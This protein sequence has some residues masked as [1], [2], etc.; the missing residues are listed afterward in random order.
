MKIRKIVFW[1]HLIAGVLASV[2]ILI[3]SFTGVLLAYETQII[4]RAESSLRRV[5]PPTVGKPLS[6]DLLLNKARAAASDSQPTGL[7]IHSEPDASLLVNFGREDVLYINPY[8]G[9]VLGHGSKMRRL[10]QQIE[11][12]HR[13]LGAG[14]NHRPAA[15][16]VASAGNFVFL[17]LAISGL[18][19][20]WPRN[21]SWN[22][23]RPS[24]WFVGG[25]RGKARDWNWHN[26]I[27]LWC[28][29]V[30]IILTLTGVVMSYQ[31]ANNLL[32]KLTGNP[33][34]PPQVE[35]SGGSQRREKPSRNDADSEIDESASLDVLVIKAQ[36]Q[37][38]GWNTLNFRLP[39]RPGAPVIVSIQETSKP[40]F[41]RSQLTLNSS[42]A[43]VIKWEP[44][45]A[46][47]SGRKLRTW[48][49]FLHTGEAGGMVGQTIAGLA[50]AGGVVLVCTGLA[51]ACR[52]FFGRRSPA[53]ST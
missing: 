3:M 44:F 13:W 28:S 27:G 12:W 32:Y 48:A 21:W 4:N 11:T 19:L 45:S 34:P 37:M 49:R 40:S 20:W 23:L 30:L 38:P 29:P 1:L 39:Q 22:A 47:N 52:R 15:L 33:P 50:S 17:F 5:V 10:M 51:M 41:Y 6:F 42:T 16:A 2:V 25:L 9:E 8:T 43:E 14:E 24:V 18:Y 53:A 35:R 7:L 36:Q 31:W 26:A 46:Q